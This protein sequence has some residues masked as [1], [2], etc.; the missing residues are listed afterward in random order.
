MQYVQMLKSVLQA[1]LIVLYIGFILVCSFIATS[2]MD[3]IA[4]R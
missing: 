1:K 2:P 3:C 4:F